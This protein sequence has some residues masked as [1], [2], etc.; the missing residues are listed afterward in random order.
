MRL[1]RVLTSVSLAVC[2]A[3]L[4]ALAQQFDRAVVFGDSLS[5]NGNIAA[6]NGGVVPNYLPLLLQRFS[7]GPVWAEQAFGGA[8]NSSRPQIPTQAT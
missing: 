5:D 4:P 6:A 7:N 2:F 3:A 1:V 8:T